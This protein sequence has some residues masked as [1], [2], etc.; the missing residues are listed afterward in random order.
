MGV[1]VLDPPPPPREDTSAIVWDVDTG[2]VLVQV[3]HGSP[4]AHARIFPDG[5]RVI[6]CGEGVGGEGGACFVWRA[7]TGRTLCSL[8]SVRMQTVEVR[9]V[10]RP[11]WW[12]T[13]RPHVRASGFRSCSVLHR[14]RVGIP[15]RRSSSLPSRLRPFRPIV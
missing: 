2:D 11:A 12:W 14:V 6:S 8:D 1:Q 9:H 15:R 10:A 13:G 7:A 4:V 5:E 3:A